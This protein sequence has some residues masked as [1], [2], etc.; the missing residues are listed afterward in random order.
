MV[1]AKSGSIIF[2]KRTSLGGNS[3]VVSMSGVEFGEAVLTAGGCSISAGL[4]SFDEFDKPIMDQK[5]Y[6]KGPIIIGGFSWLGTNVTVVDGV[7]IGKGAIVGALSLVN[8]DIDD[9]AIA[10]G[11]P[12]KIIR[13]REKVEN[14][15][16][17]LK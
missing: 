4:Y 1:L 13:Y 5:V 2:R 12:A 16:T 14:K 11:I 7:K 15:S 8:K 10:V 3:A 9:Y 17:F 6:S